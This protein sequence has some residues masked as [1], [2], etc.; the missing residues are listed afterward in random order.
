MKRYGTM[1]ATEFNKNSLKPLYMLSKNGSLKVEK[2][3]MNYIYDLADYYGYDFNRS[4]EDDERH[5]KEIIQY[6]S[7][8]DLETA[9]KKIN[10]Y[11]DSVFNL[12]SKKNQKSC[13]HEYVH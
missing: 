7:Q 13:N 11:T 8:N 1:F 9:Q 10:E 5:I 2:W 6:V 3:A 12:L 4:V